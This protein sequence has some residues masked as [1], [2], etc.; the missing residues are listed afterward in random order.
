MWVFDLLCPVL[1]QNRMT[2]SRLFGLLALTGYSL[3]SEKMKRV[4]AKERGDGGG[5]GWGGGGSGG[6]GA[7]PTWLL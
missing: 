2:G 3:C 5:G 7:W 1:S 4:K 6:R